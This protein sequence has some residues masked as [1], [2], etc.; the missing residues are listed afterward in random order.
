MM[1]ATTALSAAR[2]ED[3]ICHALRGEYLTMREIAAKL[4]QAGHHLPREQLCEVV[5]RLEEQ[6]ILGVHKSK[7]R[8][9]YRLDWRWRR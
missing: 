8:R 1:D 2:I 5:W 6:G 3:A 4:A 9:M 7:G